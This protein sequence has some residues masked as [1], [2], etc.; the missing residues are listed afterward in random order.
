MGWLT[1]KGGV[2]QRLAVF[3]LTVSWG[4]SS[5]VSSQEGGLTIEIMQFAVFF[6]QF[7][8]SESPHAQLLADPVSV[9]HTESRSLPLTSPKV[10]RRRGPVAAFPVG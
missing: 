2:S 4:V 8:Q 10:R 6:G 9:S 3:R 5:P 1:D 7:R